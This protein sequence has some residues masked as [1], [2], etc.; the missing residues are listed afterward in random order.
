MPNFRG[1]KLFK[2]QNKF[3]CT[4]FTQLQC[5][6]WN[7]WA[8]QIYCTVEPPLAGTR[9]QRP[10]FFRPGGQKIHTLTLV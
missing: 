6:C 5:T 8:L 7:I 10:L 3:G 4:L 9:K 2:K 1:L